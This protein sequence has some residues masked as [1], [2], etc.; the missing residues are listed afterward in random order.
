MKWQAVS[1]FFTKR[2]EIKYDPM[3]GFYLYVFEGDKCIHDYLQ[4]TL[5]LAMECA[6]EDFGVP[7]SAWKKF[8]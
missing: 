4:D 6:W 7:K 3:V 5:D 2:Y 8:E 1:P